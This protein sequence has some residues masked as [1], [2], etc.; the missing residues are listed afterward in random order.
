MDSKVEH[1][2]EEEAEHEHELEQGKYAAPEEEAQ[3]AANGAE[4]VAE[5][6]WVKLGDLHVQRLVE[7]LHEHCVVLG[8]VGRKLPQLPRPVVALLG[9]EVE[10]KVSVNRLLDAG[11]GAESLDHLETQLICQE[12]KKSQCLSAPLFMSKS[13]I[14][15][16]I[17]IIFSSALSKE[18]SEYFYSILRAESEFCNPEKYFVLSNT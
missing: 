18:L 7:K 13:F 2:D 4:Q 1:R 14:F 6:E 12:L 16:A 10:R 9:H 8:P 5:G 3:G 17:R 11:C 15:Q